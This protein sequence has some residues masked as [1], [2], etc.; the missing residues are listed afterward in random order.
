MKINCLIFLQFILI[1][2]YLIDIKNLEIKY[3]SPV[4][5]NLRKIH[6]TFDK[7]KKLKNFVEFVAIFSN[8]F[9]GGVRIETIEKYLN[10]SIS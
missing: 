1:C 6:R 9:V 10:T 7:S 3:L 4:S 5:D 2:K 8:V